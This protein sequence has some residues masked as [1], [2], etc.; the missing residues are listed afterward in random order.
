MIRGNHDALLDYTR[1]G[2]IDE[3]VVVLDAAQPTCRVGDAAI[4]GLGFESRHYRVEPAAALSGAR[5]R[6]SSMSG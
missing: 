5:S 1:Y 4:H 6:G 3:G 2:P